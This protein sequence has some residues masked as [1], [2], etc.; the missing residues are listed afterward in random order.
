MPTK[1]GLQN[2]TYPKEE[3][4][5][6]LDLKKTNKPMPNEYLKKKYDQFTLNTKSDQLEY[7]GR[8]LV[9]EHRVREVID[10][11]YK[12]SFA[13]MNRLFQQ[14]LR[15]YIGVS[16]DAVEAYVKNQEVQQVHDQTTTP[17]LKQTKER[18]MPNNPMSF[19]QI[20]LSFYGRRVLFVAIDVLSKF[21]YTTVIPNKEGKTVAEEL[22]K[23][24]ASSL[25]QSDASCVADSVKT[26]G[27]DNGSEFQGEFAQV[28]KE[29]GIKHVLGRSYHPQ[30]QAIVERVNRTLKSA[31]EKYHTNGGKA[32][33][34][35]LKRWVDEYNNTKHSAT[36]LAP[37]DVKG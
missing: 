34:S 16:Q 37:N 8:V 23:Y 25:G 18:P 1:R 9:P 31:L 10:E 15:K 4:L 19:V 3:A 6:V 14:I 5:S 7:R 36:K 22:K 12:K 11:E 33:Q 17:S 28:L 21:L 27:T 30:S 29:K 24:L 13:G 2:Y 26:I 32:W 35:F 20:D